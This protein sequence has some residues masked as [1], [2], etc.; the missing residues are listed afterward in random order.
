M[1]FRHAGE[2]FFGGACDGFG[3]DVADQSHKPV[4][5]DKRHL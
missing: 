2:G 4:Q 1:L 3:D 5:I